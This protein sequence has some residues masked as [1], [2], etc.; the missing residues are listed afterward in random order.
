MREKEGLRALPGAGKE[1]K[2]REVDPNLGTLMLRPALGEVFVSL[3]HL[4]RKVVNY[5]L[6]AGSLGTRAG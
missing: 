2:T 4:V 1:Q 6:E 5:S 3:K